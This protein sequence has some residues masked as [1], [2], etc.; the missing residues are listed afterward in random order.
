MGKKNKTDLGLVYKDATFSR[1]YRE[2]Q[3]IDPFH[4]YLDKPN[5]HKML[6]NL[7]GK[8]VLCLGCGGG[9]EC[10][11]IKRRGASRVI[12]IDLSEAMIEHARSTYKGIDFM[13]MSLDDIQIKNEKFDVVY[14]DMSVHYASSIEKLMKRVSSLL[15]RKGLFIFSMTHPLYDVLVR[16]PPM[17]NKNGQHSKLFGYVNK[18]GKYTIYGDYFSSRKM[19]SFW[20]DEG[21]KVRFNYWPLGRTFSSAKQA[22]LA[23][24]TLL[25]PKLPKNASISNKNAY[26]RYRKIPRVIIFRFVKS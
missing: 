10:A 6:P 9:A 25:E 5:M 18:N 4:L 14:A 13:V 7:K 2:A 20:F 24:D 17:G 21:S 12:G 3:K 8:S 19:E 15:K 26:E 16:E 11:Y 1:K 22:G 23:L